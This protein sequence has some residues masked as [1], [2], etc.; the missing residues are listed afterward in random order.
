MKKVVT[1]FA[2]NRYVSSANGGSQR[3]QMPLNLMATLGGSV[4]M[5]LEITMY[6]RST[7]AQ[8]LLTPYE[9][10]K[11]DPRPCLNDFSGKRIGDPLDPFTGIGLTYLDITTSYSGLVDVL[12]EVKA[13]TGTAQEWVDAEIRATLTYT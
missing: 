3:Y 4:A 7:N 10:T 13:G 9:G 2:R 11:H 5:R 1:V 12:M 6:A 8:I